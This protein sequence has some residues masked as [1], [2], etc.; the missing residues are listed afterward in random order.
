[1]IDAVSVACPEDIA[2][3]QT[4][5]VLFCLYIKVKINW[6][7]TRI[8]FLTFTFGSV[9]LVLG[10]VILI[11]PPGKPELSKFVFPEQ[12]PLP[13]WE[14]SENQPQPKSKDTQFIAQKDYRYNRNNQR[15]NIE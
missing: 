6:K 12:V 1:M 11:P 4:R 3:L 9:L 5:C 10:K 13:Q 14:Q 8:P 15:L 2:Q 7:Q